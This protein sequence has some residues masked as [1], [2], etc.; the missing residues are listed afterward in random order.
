MNFH[1]LEA[2]N[3]F[4][5]FELKDLYEMFTQFILDQFFSPRIRLPYLLE[6]N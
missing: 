2:M 3:P 4:P 6:N 1:L 5:K